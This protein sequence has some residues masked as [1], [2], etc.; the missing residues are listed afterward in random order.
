[1][2]YLHTFNGRLSASADWSSLLL[3]AALY[4][5]WEQSVRLEKERK[6]FPGE[7]SGDQFSIWELILQPPPPT[8]T[9][10]TMT[11][12]YRSILIR[13]KAGISN[14]SQRTES[15]WT[16]RQNHSPRMWALFA[17]L[18]TE[19]WLRQVLWAYDKLAKMYTYF[20]IMEATSRFLF[21]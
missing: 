8:P 19:Q 7:Y 6:K 5:T 21:N 18:D 11:A 1:M 3:S 14:M 10:C 17:S 2:T 15:S 9:P 12:C 13:D 16:C 20:H 4:L